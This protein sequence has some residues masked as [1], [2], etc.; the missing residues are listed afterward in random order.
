MLVVIVISIWIFFSVTNP[1][2]S[3]E[4]T[5]SDTAKDKTVDESNPFSAKEYL[6]YFNNNLELPEIP[7]YVYP[8]TEF[9]FSGQKP[10]AKQS[11]YMLSGLSKEAFLN[12]VHQLGL[13]K[14]SDLFDFWPD[15]FDDED[16]EDVFDNWDVTKSKNEYTYYGQSPSYQIEMAARY[17]NE[18][19]YIRTRATEE[20]ILDKKNNVTGQKVLPRE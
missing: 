5:S 14:N 11:A 17:E 12:L 20:L 6:I 16:L 3:L 10:T 8:I 15:V 18:K 2:V 1:K 13:K 19:A 7:I 4:V 9:S